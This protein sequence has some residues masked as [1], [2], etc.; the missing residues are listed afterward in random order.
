LAH[1]YTWLGLWYVIP[2][3]AAFAK[4]SDAAGHA[5]A[6][7][8]DDPVALSASAITALWHDWDW[9]KAERL[10][11][12]AAD[13]GA[14]VALGH[15]GMTYVRLT[16]GDVAAAIASAERAVLIDPLSNA[17]RTDL[18]DALRFAGRHDEARSI[19]EPLLKREPDHLL[20]NLWMGYQLE[21]L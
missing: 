6:I 18:A 11:W 19:L 2:A 17:A 13:I 1:S 20:A 14:G 10:A 7:D 5:L 9:E 3:P 8:P 16:S 15:S 4:V 12:R 21:R